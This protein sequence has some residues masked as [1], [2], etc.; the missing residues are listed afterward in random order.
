M[1]EGRWAKAFFASSIVRWNVPSARLSDGPAVNGPIGTSP[2]H[3]SMFGATP[4]GSGLQPRC[5]L[6]R[7]TT[8][9]VPSSKLRCGYHRGGKTD[10]LVYGV[11]HAEVAVLT[12]R[13]MSAFTL[14]GP[15]SGRTQGNFHRPGRCGWPPRPPK[16]PA[17]YPCCASLP[18]LFRE[19]CGS[20]I[21][22]C[23]PERAK[24]LNPSLHFVNHMT[25][26]RHRRGGGGRRTPSPRSD[27]GWGRG[28]SQK[29]V[30]Q[31]PDTYGRATRVCAHP[32]TCTREAQYR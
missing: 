2:T 18:P 7:R 12:M 20:Q 17:F 15:E 27:L 10:A 1:R 13:G 31:P 23:R 5:G 11:A 6:P 32:A 22:P 28:A 9:T 30:S 16:R 8:G 4:E 19:C 29:R 3:G 25:R 21:D 26:T 24:M 14:A